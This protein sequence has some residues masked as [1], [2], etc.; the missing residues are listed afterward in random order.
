VYNDTISEQGWAHFTINTFNHLRFSKEDQMF[1]AGTLEG[2][3]TARRITE[4]FLNFKDLVIPFGVP[5]NLTEYFNQQIAWIQEL[6][7]KYSDDQYWATAGLVMKQLGGIVNGLELAGVEKV[8][9]LDI[10][11][12][13]S[14]TDLGDLK[15]LYPLP[16]SPIEEYLRY[17]LVEF[18]SCSAYIGVLNDSNGNVRRYRWARYLV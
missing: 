6:V 11:M 5:D 17:K 4:A 15:S 7:E 3:M 12:L 18:S 2:Y 9:F 8:S 1:A 13:N 14:E 10:F 16:T